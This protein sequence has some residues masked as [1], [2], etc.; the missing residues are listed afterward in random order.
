M[1]VP[2][3]PATKP[4]ARVSIPRWLALILAPF[5]W[6][7]AIPLVHGVVPWAISL[8]TTQHG[9]ANDRPSPLNL[10]G[11]IPVIAGAVM[12]MWVFILGYVHVNEIPERVELNWEPKLFFTRGPYAFTRNPMYVA[13]LSLWLG[14]AILYGSLA[15]LAGFVVMCIGVSFVIRREERDLEARFGAAYLQYKTFAPRWLGKPREGV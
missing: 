5:V 3:P 14:W 4:S 12:L 7:V 10:L 9:W 15:V 13:E 6:L 2:T 8:L 1:D 11:L